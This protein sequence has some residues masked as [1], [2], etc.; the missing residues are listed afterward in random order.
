MAEIICPICDRPNDANAERCWFCQAILPKE[1]ATPI[2]PEGNWLDS[3]RDVSAPQKEEPAAQPVPEPPTNEDEVPDWLARIRLREQ[4]QRQQQI[5]ENPSAG[6]SEEDTPDWLKEIQAGKSLAG[7]KPASETPVTPDPKQHK[8]DTSSLDNDD[9]L[10]SLSDW[11]EPAAEAPLQEETPAP[12]GKQPE[13]SA[14]SVAPKATPLD[15][16]D[17][18]WLK[19]FIE[20]PQASDSRSIPEPVQAEPPTEAENVEPEATVPESLFPTQQEPEQTAIE[21][22]EPDWLSDF[23]ALN[24]EADLASQVIPPARQ[25][26]TVKPAFDDS[27]LM[28]WMS[29]QQPHTDEPLPEVAD[30]QANAASPVEADS[31]AQETLYAEEAAPTEKLPS[32]EETPAAPFESEADGSIAKASLPPWLQALRPAKK[33]QSEKTQELNPQ[34]PLAGIEGT[35]LQ[36]N[37]Q[38]FYTK[39]QTYTESLEITDA[40][41]K[42]AA[43]LQK[44]VQ[45]YHWDEEEETEKAS[46]R[47]WILRLI[48]SLLLLVAAV[49]PPMLKGL[50]VALPNLY[51]AE[52]VDM[53]NGING[54]APGTP[55]LV[56]ADFDGS[57]YGELSLSSKAVLEHLMKRN[58]PIVSLSTT[59]TGSTLLQS[60]LKEAA[61]RQ[62]AYPLTNLVNFGYLPG[63]S[64]GLQALAA[65]PVSALPKDVN[66]SV[67]WS[68]EPLQAVKKLSDLGAVLVIT[69]NADTARFWVEQVQPSLGATP[70]Y[71]IISAQS[72][73]L[74]QPY[75]D[76]KQINGY[77]AG[78][79]AGTVYELLDANPGTASASYPAYQISLLIVTLMILIA[80]I[81]VLVSPR[82]PSERAER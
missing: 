46:P 69:E 31:P 37:I 41:K 39:P 16:T 78:L 17:A 3:F 25:D 50:P 62:T 58:L 55:V 23:K 9:W 52:V 19:E 44:M 68:E 8:K 28:N 12:A 47:T 40:Q 70:L 20:E 6:E 57:L 71:V 63:G 21:D 34:N 80:G 33:T 75:Y 29:G 77:L 51:P 18:D 49:L 59:P 5:E 26:D 7:E 30:Q 24:P 53:Y 43:T 79:N 56:A 36:E 73:P 67:P 14:F 54:L 66:L 42:R 22:A 64:M 27:T 38:Q 15:A 82:Q 48:V 72:A 4:E 13:E 74:I 35:L 61:A 76:S 60:L 1:A 10:K 65:D 81:V 32:N 45:P 11:Q 2:D